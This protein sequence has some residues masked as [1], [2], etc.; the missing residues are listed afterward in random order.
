MTKTVI[1]NEP[2]DR[3]AVWLDEAGES[4]EHEP[5]A[6]NLATCTREGKPSNRMVLLKDHGPDGFVFYTNYEGRK[7]QELLMNPFASVCFHWKGLKRQVR[8][9]GRVEQVSNDEADVY[10]D[11]RALNSRLGAWASKQSRPL[12]S[13]ARFL[14]DVAKVTAKFAGRKVTRPEFWSGFRIVPDTIEL[15]EDGAFRLHERYQYK[16]IDGGWTVTMLYP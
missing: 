13:K 1:H 6:M 12:E 11:S 2:F 16:K 14:A 10:Y 9:E 3:F 7:G 8:V 4:G 15:W 5:N